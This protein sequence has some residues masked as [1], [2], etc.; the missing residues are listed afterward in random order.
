MSPERRRALNAFV[1]DGSA[2]SH[3]YG[4]WDCCLVGAEAVR[5]Q[6]GDDHGE[7]YQGTYS[8]AQGALRR[9]KEVDGVETVEALATKKLGEP[10]HPAYARPG[11][12]VLHED[13][14]GVFFNG[15][16]L[17]AGDNGWVRVPRSELVRAW[18]V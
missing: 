18:R 7:P 17:F 4:A 6:T 8:T 9:M 11:D 15:V 14:L 16:G 3:E 5:V 12:I 1:R 13:R 2:R 10:V